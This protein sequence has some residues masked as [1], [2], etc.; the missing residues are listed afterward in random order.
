MSPRPD[1]A[2]PLRCHPSASVSEIEAVAEDL[3]VLVE[4]FEF[5]MREGVV[6]REFAERLSEL[7]QSAERI[8]DL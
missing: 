3:I 6:P 1:S 4:E 5:A 8:I 7:R 2:E